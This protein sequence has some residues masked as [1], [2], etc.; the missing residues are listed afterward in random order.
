ML[1]QPTPEHGSLLKSPLTYSSAAVLIVLLVVGFIMYTRWENKRALEQQGS[2]KRAEQQRE[3]DRA[4]VDELGGKEFAILDFYAAPQAI[5]RGESA[6]LCY[7]VSN[8]KSVKLE[9]QP[10]EV[11]PSAANCVDVSPAKTTTYTLTIL[12]AEGHSESQT[13][14]LAVR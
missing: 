14:E 2:E 9:P 10:H 1:S 6:Q 7:G 13:L 4:A 3:Q 8:A 11:W 12:D 5:Q